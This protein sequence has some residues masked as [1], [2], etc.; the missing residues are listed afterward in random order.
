M[1]SS[2]LTHLLSKCRPELAIPGRRT[3]TAAS[4]MILLRPGSSGQPEE[5]F[6][7]LASP[8]ALV[9]KLQANDQDFGLHA[10]LQIVPLWVKARATWVP[11]VDL[12]QLSAV[13]SCG[14]S[15]FAGRKNN[16]WHGRA[17]L[18]VACGLVPALAFTHER[19]TSFF[20]ASASE[21]QQQDAS[22]YNSGFRFNSTSGPFS[23]PP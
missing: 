16:C 11:R 9:E 13:T 3:P 7:E 8:R 23:R 17:A 15:C 5:C 2:T 19:H 4:A 18:C 6:L 22:C 1:L 12:G 14:R 21:H 10:S 20:T